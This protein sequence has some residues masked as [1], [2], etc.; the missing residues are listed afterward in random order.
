MAKI[1][2]KKVTPDSVV[3]TFSNGF[4]LDVKR[5]KFNAVMQDRLMLHGLSQKIGDS[6]ASCD[7]VEDAIAEAKAT[8]ASLENGNWSEGRSSDGGILAEA[9]A[10]IKKLDIA[11]VAEKLES[12]TDEEKIALRKNPRIKAT[13]DTIRGERATAK[14]DTLKDEK[15]PGF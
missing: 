9:I 7:T 8:L 2:S 12:A 4:T 1:A 3:F 5:E 6:Y 10:R 13:I 14:L 15:I 11:K